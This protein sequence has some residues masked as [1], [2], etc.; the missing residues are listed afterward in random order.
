VLDLGTLSA[1]PQAIY[2]GNSEFDQKRFGLTASKINFGH[3]NLAI[4]AGYMDSSGLSS[5]DGAYGS[6]SF[7]T[8]F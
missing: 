4:S 8:N 3:L 5:D 7:S 2:L 6:V 1:G